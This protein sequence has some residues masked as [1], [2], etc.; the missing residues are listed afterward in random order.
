MKSAFFVFAI[1][2]IGFG[3]FIRLAP[4]DPG[5]WHVDPLTAK[6]GRKKNVF[7]QLPGEGKYPSPEFDFG[8]EL[9]AHKFSELVLK[10]PD[11]SVLAGTPNDLFMTFIA[12]TKLMRYP[13]YISIR[14][15]DLGGDRSTLAVFSRSRFG[16]SD[17]GVNRRRFL[18]WQDQL[19]VE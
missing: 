12:R 9:L 4:S 5:F 7:I 2:L 6:K 1:T 14:F 13:D 18:A 16:H 17:R 15:I 10:N 8:A 3:F 11:V 19:I